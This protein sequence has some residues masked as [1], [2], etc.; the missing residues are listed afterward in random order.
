MTRL[1]V[2]SI[3][4]LAVTSVASAQL[5]GSI[6]L[7]S[8]A[9]GTD[10]A[11][12]PG[13]MELHVIHYGHSGATSSEFMLEISAW[14]THLGDEWDLAAMGSSVGGVYVVYG[15]C[16]SPPTH[17]GVVRF[18]DPIAQPCSEIRVGP[19]PGNLNI[20]TVD[21]AS[22]LTFAGGDAILANC[23]P[24]GVN[25]PYN[26]QPADGAGG[27]SLSP[28]LSWSWAE[29]T[30]CIEGI[31]ITAF[32][33]YMGTEPDNLTVAG[34]LDGEKTLSVG[35]LQPGTTYYWQVSVWDDYYNCPGE[36]T[37]H[38]A[39]HSFTTT[40]PVPVEQTTWGRIKS[41]YR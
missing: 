17:L 38:S 7:F 21:C 27:I 6:G 8:D 32:T 25:P 31:G 11:V 40:G 20:E 19:A 23:G 5:T 39:V 13:L 10:C 14:W 1:A 26:L 22:T 12:G 33:I 2:I 18:F 37:A 15:G 24:C 41:L 34:W 35:P 28:T 30:G 36:Q 4:I 29:P 3:A 16:Q 9:E